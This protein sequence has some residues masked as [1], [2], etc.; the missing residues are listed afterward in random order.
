MAT[1]NDDLHGNAPDSAPVALLI[2][3]MI[4]DLEFPGGENVLEPAEK[5]A[6]KIAH[7]KKQAK[8]LKIPVI[9][10]N[11]NF[12]KWRSDFNELI[13]HC[14]N[15]GV[16]GQRLV[17]LLKPDREDYIVLKPKHSIFF[18]TTLDALLTYLHVEQLVIMGISA[19]VCV[20]FSANDAYM[21]DFGLYV[22][23]DCVASQSAE[24]TKQAVDYMARVLRADT[25]P[26][27]KLDLSRL[28][29]ESS[30]VQE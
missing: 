23:A 24:N 13:D 19:D 5:A 6:E 8:E 11:D 16:R 2:I 22:P 7:L 20:Q 26:S 9:Y 14:L 27:D 4:N 3:D 17:E 21:R 15:D 28:L 12:G 10:A 25:T 18:A 30:S 29:Q 1:N